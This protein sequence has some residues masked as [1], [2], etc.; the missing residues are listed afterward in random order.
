MFSVKC[1]E[2]NYIF[3]NSRP[4][5]VFA[6]TPVDTKMGAD[7]LSS[8]GID[9]VMYPVSN[10][11][12][13]QHLFQVSSTEEKHSVMSKMLKKS[14][15]EGCE[16]A[17]IYCN[18]LSGSVDFKRLSGELD[19]KIITPMDAH[20]EIAKT[21]R[22]IA[23]IAYN[24]QALSGIELAAIHANPELI[25]LSSSVMP[26]VYDI[27]EGLSPDDII[28]RNHLA[29]LCEYY[30]ACGC[31]TLVLGCTH[32]PYLKEALAGRTSLKITDPA[33]EMIRLLTAQ[34]RL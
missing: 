21:H 16:S 25:L 3:M 2:R 10:D 17:F 5:A 22:K 32:F 24:P 34:S 26:V 27:E 4:V 18:S 7:L 30:K 13:E 19:L 8:H 6:G 33:E 23:V 9:S 15:S 1:T 14:M 29:E 11:P 12:H 20:A 28:D 31:E